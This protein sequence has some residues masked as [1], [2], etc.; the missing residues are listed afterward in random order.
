MKN[1][2]PV[3]KMSKRAQRELAKKH[4]GSWLG[5]DPVTRIKPNDRKKKLEKA[6]YIAAISQY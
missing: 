6:R 2:V 4:R 3:E 5:V 1:F